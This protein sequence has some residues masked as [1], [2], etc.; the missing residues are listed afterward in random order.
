MV[1]AKLESQDLGKRE[2]KTPVWAS[3][4]TEKF[5]CS[6]RWTSTQ[7]PDTETSTKIHVGNYHLPGKETIQAG[8]KAAEE[9]NH[10]AS[11][12]SS[13]GKLEIARV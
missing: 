13:V 9:M 1:Q 5:S 10:L 2:D 8:S 6:K 4:S 12:S 7:A 11:T 3:D